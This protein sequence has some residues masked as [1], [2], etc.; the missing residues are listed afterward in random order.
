MEAKLKKSRE[1]RKGRRRVSRGGD[2]E[3]KERRRRKE[4]G[5]WVKRFIQGLWVW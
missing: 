4:G 1:G 5:G 3:R 2:R